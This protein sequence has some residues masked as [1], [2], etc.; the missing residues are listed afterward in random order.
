M[1]RKT[2]GSIVR[3]VLPE[4]MWKPGYSKVYQDKSTSSKKEKIRYKF[5]YL[6]NMRLYDEDLYEWH[7][8]KTSLGPRIKPTAADRKEINTRRT[9]LENKI[10]QALTTAGIDG[11]TRVRLGFGNGDIYVYREYPVTVVK[12]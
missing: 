12:G 5:T 1:A 2:V 7:M 10:L 8:N 6:H 11:V 3:S 9:D 4:G